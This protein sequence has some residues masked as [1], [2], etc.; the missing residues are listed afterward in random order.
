MIEGSVE[1][2]NFIIGREVGNSFGFWILYN[3]ISG[4]Y[5]W[6]SSRKF[7]CIRFVKDIRLSWLE[8][9]R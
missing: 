8:R 9:V 4:F 7:F 3:I 2:N 5:Y 6:E 1:E